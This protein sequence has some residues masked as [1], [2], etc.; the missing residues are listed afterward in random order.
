MS[1]TDTKWTGSGGPEAVPSILWDMAADCL[2]AKDWADK[3]ARYDDVHP[4]DVARYED[5]AAMWQIAS[6]EI[7]LAAEK[8]R[9]L[10]APKPRVMA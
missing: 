4:N 8:L 5:E 6:R 1:F 3:E 10:L 7:A 2:R 9:A